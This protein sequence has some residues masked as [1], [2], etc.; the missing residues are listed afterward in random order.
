LASANRPLPIWRAKISDRLRFAL[1]L[2]SLAAFALW[3]VDAWIAAGS[4]PYP[5]C[6]VGASW[7][8]V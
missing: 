6:G 8:S 1:E 5:T 3:G 4:I 2:A 7:T